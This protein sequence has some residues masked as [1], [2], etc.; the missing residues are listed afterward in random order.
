MKQRISLFILCLLS[1]VSVMS[2]PM[3]DE[4]FALR[5]RFPSRDNEL[6]ADLEKY[7]AA[8]PY[9][10]YYDDAQM[11]LG[12]IHTEKKQYKQALRNFRNVD[13]KQLGRYD[14][15]MFFFYRGYAFMQSG[16]ADAAISCFKVLKESNNP[17]TLQGRYYYAYCMYKNGQYKEALPDFLA[18]EKTEQYGSIVPYYIVQIYYTQGK[19]DEVWERAKELLENDPSNANNAEIYRIVG[20]MYYNKGQYGKSAEQLEKY[21]SIMNKKKKK[22]MRNDLYLMGIAYYKQKRYDDA[23]R[24]LKQVK[25]EKDTISES[26]C[27]HLGHAYVKTGQWE[28]AQLAYSAAMNFRLNNKTREEAMYNYA[29]TT[30]QK[31]TALG[32]SVTAFNNFLNEYPKTEIR[33]TLH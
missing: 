8:Y 9:T 13:W 23:I 17:Y 31:N 30:Y 24:S 20:E 6:K 10:T 26:T 32:E 12:V 28:S 14:Q 4:F 22:L 5:N 29:L 11:M 19:Y 25:Q 18:L 1:A 15:P 16:D 3:E 21:A 33:K 7:L 27:L 2:S